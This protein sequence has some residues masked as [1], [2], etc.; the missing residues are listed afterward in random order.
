M[1]D[2]VPI[3]VPD[4]S[5]EDVVHALGRLGLVGL[6]LD[7]ARVGFPGWVLARVHGQDGNPLDLDGLAPEVY[8]EVDVRRRTGDALPVVS[9]DEVRAALARWPGVL[10]GADLRIGGVEPMFPL[11]ISPQLPYATVAVTPRTDLQLGVF[12][13]V[14][15]VT[16]HQARVDDRLV[17]GLEGADAL[18]DDALVDALVNARGISVVLWRRGPCTGLHV[19]RR[20][21]HRAAHVWVPRWTPLGHPALDDLRGDLRP[22]EGD[23]AQLGDLLGL[24]PPDV[25]TLRAMLRRDEPDL[26]A[27][28][29]LLGLP[30]EISDVLEARRR[31]A[32]LPD[33]Q[34]C[35]PLGWRETLVEATRSSEHDPRWLQAFERGPRELRPWYV[36]SG[37]VWIALCCWLVAGWRGGGSIFWGVVGVVG[38]LAQVVDLAVRWVLKRRRSAG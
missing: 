32:D 16:L 11:L 27:L 15:D 29:A 36:L 28:A 20:G 34:E 25:V 24:D 1:E 13:K 23:A 21:K 37:L 7:G 38:G 33:A 9:H 12:A 26:P 14:A 19:L 17:V 2:L 4:A 35:V 8:P 30:A 6:A 3:A 22:V 31:V 18:T 5:T 10:L